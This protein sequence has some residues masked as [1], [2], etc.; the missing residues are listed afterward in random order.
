M[1]LRFLNYRRELEHFKMQVCAKTLGY[2]SPG[3]FRSRLENLKI[4]RVN[5]KRNCDKYTGVYIR[6][7]EIQYRP[8]E[9]GGCL[10]LC[11]SSSW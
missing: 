4:K 7:P 5:P 6:I 10:F 2:D 11:L 8:I 1:H 3:K 9:V